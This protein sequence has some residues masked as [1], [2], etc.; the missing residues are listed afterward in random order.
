M[1]GFEFFLVSEQQGLKP[2]IDGVLG[3]SRD[4]APP[5][6]QGKEWR[7]VGPIYVKKL[8]EAGVI[9]DNIFAFYL[10]SFAE[11]NG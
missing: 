8:A 7:G 4:L 9:E 3:M 1:A 11:E 5:E 2:F 6:A 10:E